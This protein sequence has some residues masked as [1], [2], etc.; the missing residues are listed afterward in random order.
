MLMTG[1]KN[2]SHR[3]R[4]ARERHVSIRAIRRE[5]IDAHKLARALIALAQAEAAAQAEHESKKHDDEAADV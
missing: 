1:G 5:N 3:S 2:K 4:R